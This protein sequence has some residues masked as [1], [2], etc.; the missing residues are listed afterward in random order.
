M[1]PE[2]AA[3]AKDV[4]KRLAR[5][6]PEPRC[7][8]DHKNPWQLLVATILS[9][10][11]TDKK[12]NE[13]SPALFARWP[14]PAAL[15]AA[16]KEDVEEAVKQTGFFRNK[17]RAIMEASRDIEERFG[18]QVPRTLDELVTLRGVARKT[19]NV[20]LGTAYGIASGITVDTHV[21]RVSR[22]LEL[23]TEEDPV[24]IEA[25]LCELFPRAQ[26][27]D[28]GHRMVLH[29]RYVC[30]AKKPDCAN[31]PLNELCPVAEAE[32]K[33]AWTARADR[34]RRL[35]ESKGART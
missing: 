24:A 16:P 26:W 13:I 12:V 29:G 10:Q 6:I 2:L 1:H 32:P 14:T 8:L 33:G 19:A 22:K 25:E 11:S 4:A 17:A 20:V 30:Q 34:E 23:A 7:E 5:A 9:A 3:H 28:L 21:T 18:G 35:V 27:I 15:A 31:C